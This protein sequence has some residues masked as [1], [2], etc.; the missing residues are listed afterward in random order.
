MKKQITLLVLLAAFS[1]LSYGQAAGNVIYNNP[2][3]VRPQKMTINY[4]KGYDSSTEL[5][6]EILMNI[7]ASSYTVIFSATQN[8]AT[9]IEADSLMNVRLKIVE[10]ELLAIG[11]KKSDMHVDLISFVPTYSMVLEEKKFSKTANELPIGFQLKKN[12]HIIITNYD[13]LGL[14]TTIMAKSEIYDIVK[15]DYNLDNL[16]QHFQTIRNEAI[17]VIKLKQKDYEKMGLNITIENMYDGFNATYPL[18]RY[19]SYTAYYTGSSIEEIKVAKK[20]KQEAAKNTVV[21]GKN[22]TVNINIF[23]IQEEDDTEFIV[24]YSDKNKTIY[25]NKIPYNQFDMVLN[26]DVA[27]PQIQIVY[28]L[29]ARYRVENLEVYTERINKKKEA[30]LQQKEREG[31]KR[32]R[33]TMI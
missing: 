4:T 21:S 30:E 9:A 18:E 22:A 10:Q 19:A 7:P 5:S 26:A 16:K 31:K 1:G 20:R 27:E 33:R 14:M 2:D 29:K 6:A 11:I 24:K 25:Y 17:D 8:G 13:L 28:S 15:V 32:G 12:I 3:A 23:D